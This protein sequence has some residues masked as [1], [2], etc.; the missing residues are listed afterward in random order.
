MRFDL[1]ESAQISGEW[2][3]QLSFCFQS[4][5]RPSLNLVKKTFFG[6]WC[7][8]A[9]FINELQTIN[10]PFIW[11]KLYSEQRSLPFWLKNWDYRFGVDPFNSAD[12][13]TLT[14]GLHTHTD[15]GC[16]RSLGGVCWAF[17]RFLSLHLLGL[18]YHLWL[19]VS[20]ISLSPVSHL[21]LKSTL[22][23]PY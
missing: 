22:I 7:F 21:T 19:T 3:R 14:H 23:H 5:R 9:S 13:L 10:L 4:N 1:T 17:F 8:V 20:L 15:G 2:M 6:I 12:D 18:S 11:Y 16:L